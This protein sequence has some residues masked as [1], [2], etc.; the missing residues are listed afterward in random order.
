[1]RSN[2]LILLFLILGLIPIWLIRFLPFSDY[3]DWLY[4]G[5]LLKEFLTGTTSPLQENF[6]LV[7]VPVPNSGSTI[8][9][10]LLNL[11]LP[12][13]V[14]GKILLSIWV[15]SFPLSIIYLFRVVHSGYSS[16]ELIGFTLIYNWFF[17]AGF[18]SFIL[19]LPLVFFTL[20]Y[21]YK[22]IRELSLRQG[23]LVG[24][25]LLATYFCHL[26]GFMA[27]LI[28]LTVLFVVLRPPPK[29]FLSL[30]LASTPPLLLL[31][32][33]VLRQIS[34]STP[35]FTTNIGRKAGAFIRPLLLFFEFKPFTNL[36]FTTLANLVWLGGLLI[37]VLFS[38]KWSRKGVI[39][40]KVWLIMG[41][42]FLV[43]VLILPIRFGGTVSPDERFVLFGVIFL[44][45]SFKTTESKL[46]PLILSGLILFIIGFNIFSLSNANRDIEQL[47][48]VGLELFGDG[49][50]IQVIAIRSYPFPENCSASREVLPSVRLWVGTRQMVYSLLETKNGGV[51]SSI[52]DSGMF[53]FK[54]IKENADLKYDELDQTNFRQNP[55]AELAVANLTVHSIMVVACP[56]DIVTIIGLINPLYKQQQISTYVSIFKS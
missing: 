34:S 16:L 54:G 24:L 52:F 20:A 17:L 27:L 26:L 9:I 31:M 3:P 15:I 49:G 33:Y 45:L 46:I 50:K 8:L 48:K 19:S 44:L 35:E 47:N 21:I 36:Q 5:H 56:E 10:G 6:N 51:V 30:G 41:L 39:E 53:Q 43:V 37:A 7:F 2:Y 1:M 29:V 4:Q 42:V 38:I 23:F 32:W 28:G 25:L 13:E 11:F 12:I 22:N 40:N 18:A 55:A 14:A